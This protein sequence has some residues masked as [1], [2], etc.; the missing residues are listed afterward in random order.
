MPELL[1]DALL[2]RTAFLERLGEL[3]GRDAGAL[4][5]LGGE[6]GVGKT[7]LLRRFC[8]QQEA[9]RVLW[10]ACDALFTPRALGPFLT[11]AEET[12]GELQAVVVRGAR[13]HDIAAELFA[14]LRSEPT[15]LVLEDVHWADEATLDLVRLL[16][17]RIESTSALVVASFRDDE[18]DASH[19]LRVVLGELATAPGVVR[20]SLPP[21][22]RDAVSALAEPYGVD[23]RELHRT[24]G[25]NPFFVTEVLAAG[26]ADVPAIVRDAVLGRAARLAPAARRVLEA[27]AIVP[28]PAELWLLDALASDVEALDDCLA[29]GMLVAENGAVRFRHELARIAIEAAI[30]PHRARELHR[31]AVRTLADPSRNADPALI[32]HHAES[33][34]DDA[35]VLAFAPAAA[36][37]AVRA[38]AHREAAAHFARAIRVG[39]QLPPAERAQLLE[40]YSRECYLI[41]QF[42]EG[43][44]G[45]TEALALRRAL[46]D[47]LREG[48]ALRWQSRLLWCVGRAAEANA[49]A[50]EAVALLERLPRGPELALAYTSRAGLCMI[51]DDYV[52]AA[53]WGSL[54]VELAEE[55]A[56]VET[57]VAALSTVGAAE[58]AGGFG[59][60]AATLARSFELSKRAGLHEFAIRSLGNG[61]AAA[62]EIRSYAQADEYLAAVLAYLDSLDVIYWVDFPLA[63]RARSRFEQ[64]LWTSAAADAE[65]VLALPRTLPLSRLIALV[66]LARVRARRGDPG[67]RDALDEAAA[68][69]TPT[70]LQQAAAV[71]I[72]RAEAE[73]LDGDPTR[74]G[75]ITEASFALALERR[76]SWWLGE[77]AVLR[78]RAGIDEPPPADAAA[79]YARELAGEFE[80]AAALWAELGCPYEAALALAAAGSDAGLRRAHAELRRLGARPAAE[81]VECRLRQRGLRPA[82]GPRNSTRIN[83][84]GLT[85]REVEVLSLVAEGLH[86]PEI[87]SRLSVSGRTVDHHV[88]AVLRKLGVRT[89]VEASTEARRLGLLQDP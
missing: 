64:G 89:R 6:A 78:R 81:A 23:A 71:A 30:P 35:A 17:R 10:G 32:V 70:E 43:L 38:D 87:A 18:L 9:T 48:D 45:H 88:S 79:P 66:V 21:L 49:A 63:N 28:R 53:R 61:G 42:E 4:V 27:V 65:R 50:D 46:G 24:T 67:V 55:V 13:P 36:E 74:V 39:T 16:G 84:A 72:A 22:S 14:E 58:L 40:R 56:D 60:G 19:P 2:E 75:L 3:A 12:G 52:C 77:L 7:A 83:P 11:V 8:G 25:G 51:D 82:R 47:P 57:L 73:L 41:E 85:A 59:D 76:S 54:A 86:N 1:T 20:M 29:S 80:H 34:G 69:A 37:E 15:I 44:T 33:A 5:L 62:L 68:L 31:T 26:S